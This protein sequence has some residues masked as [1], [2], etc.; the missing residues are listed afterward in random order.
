MLG[1]RIIKSEVIEFY[2]NVIVL[3]DGRIKSKVNDIEAAETVP[4]NSEGSTVDRAQLTRSLKKNTP[5]VVKQVD[6]PTNVRIDVDEEATGS[7]LLLQSLKF[8]YCLPHQLKEAETKTQTLPAQP[9]E[10]VVHEDQSTKVVVEVAPE[11]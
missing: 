11:A 10:E 2:L 6:E 3:G 8:H 1:D 7:T 9:T 4:T 5:P